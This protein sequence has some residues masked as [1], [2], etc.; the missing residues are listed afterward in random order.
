MNNERLRNKRLMPFINQSKVL[1]SDL[2][3]VHPFKKVE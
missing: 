2:N 1:E 3:L